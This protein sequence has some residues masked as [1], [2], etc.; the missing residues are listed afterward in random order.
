MSQRAE[1]GRDASGATG[2]GLTRR[3]LLFGGVGTLAVAVGTDAG[4]AQEGGATTVEM[5]DGLVFDPQEVTVPPGGTVVWENVGQV[6]HSVTA[7][8]GEIPSDAE[9]FDSADAGSEEAARSAYPD[10]GD[11]GG[12][13]T[14]EH[15][16]DVEGSYGYFCIPHES[17][18]MVGTVT[19]AP[20]G[21]GDA[22]GGGVAPP[23]VG[24]D[25][26]LLGIATALALV[27]VVAF[28]FFLL[29]YGGDYG[30]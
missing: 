4:A 19:V 13:G 17:A 2:T 24:D 3:A 21:G 20:G 5:T 18:G 9:Y 30:E 27:A 28:T 16:F 14:Y 12:G 1:S 11:I 7:Y 22:E 15:T 23:V 8:E 26:R 25:V 10:E 6:G 29:K